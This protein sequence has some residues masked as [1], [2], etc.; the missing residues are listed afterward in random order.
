MGQVK[1]DQTGHLMTTMMIGLLTSALVSLSPW[2]GHGWLKCSCPEGQ[3]VKVTVF[4]R[5]AGHFLWCWREDPVSHP[6]GSSWGLQQTW[7]DRTWCFAAP[8]QWACLIRVTCV[9][10][11]VHDPSDIRKPT[12]CQCKIILSCWSKARPLTRACWGWW[13]NVISFD[14]N[15][16]SESV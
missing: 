4:V 6:Y 7:H 10:I 16:D 14:M 13:G 12:N 11:T 1:C 8:D 15:M 5:V 2:D 3:P 9:M